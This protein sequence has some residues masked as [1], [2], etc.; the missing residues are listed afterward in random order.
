[1]QVNRSNPK[2]ENKFVQVRGFPHKKVIE[3]IPAVKEKQLIFVTIKKRSY[4]QQRGNS[5]KTERA[6]EMIVKPCVLPPSLVKYQALIRRLSEN[7]LVKYDVVTEYNNRMTGYLGEES[8]M[9]FHLEPIA[10][11]NY[12]IYHDLRF[13]LGNYFFQID[14]LILCAYFTLV[15]EVKNWA[16][17]WHFDKVLHQTT[18]DING[19]MERTK[20]PIFQARLQAFKLREWLKLHNVTGTPIQYLFVNSNEK[21]KIIIGDDNKYKWNACNSEYLLERIDQITNDYKIELLE[22]KELRK[23]NK[24]LLTSHTAED[25]QLLSKHNLSR[26]EILTGVHCP[27]CL[28]L[29]M[30]YQSGTWKCPKSNPIKNSLHRHIS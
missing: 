15:L 16:R 9:N 4:T 2:M 23:I 13:N 29:P 14:I 27:K 3:T 12:R 1:M 25:P 7:H 8:V 21:S 5:M 30:T 20:N 19:K 11:L 6:D 28:F 24:L 17:D 26:N 10:D 18:I 22:E